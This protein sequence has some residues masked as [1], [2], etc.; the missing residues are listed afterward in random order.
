MY[1]PQIIVITDHEQFQTVLVNLAAA[2][3]FKLKNALINCNKGIS[4]ISQNLVMNSF[5]TFKIRYRKYTMKLE[6][7]ISKI[8]SVYIHHAS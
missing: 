4:K 7:L 3:S 2:R 6:K 1:V 5:D 8:Y